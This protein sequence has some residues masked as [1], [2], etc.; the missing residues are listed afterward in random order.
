MDLETLSNLHDDPLSDAEFRFCL[1][2]AIGD[3]PRLCSLLWILLGIW[4]SVMYSLTTQL[5]L[6]STSLY[7][8]G[9][10]RTYLVGSDVLLG[11]GVSLNLGLNILLIKTYVFEFFF[12]LLGLFWVLHGELSFLITCFN[13]LFMFAYFFYSLSF[14]LS[15]NALNL[16]CEGLYKFWIG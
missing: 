14:T 9:D 2:P 6:F 8:Y 12:R 13:F 15:I 16:F 1:C 11:V 7:A 3:E 4:R 5:D 10:P